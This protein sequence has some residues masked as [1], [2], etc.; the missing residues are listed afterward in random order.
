MSTILSIRKK[1]QI[2]KRVYQASRL[3][4]LMRQYPTLL[5]RPESQALNNSAT[6]RVEVVCCLMLLPPVCS[7]LAW[8]YLLM[9]KSQCTIRIVLSAP[10]ISTEFWIYHTLEYHISFSKFTIFFVT[11]IQSADQLLIELTRMRAVG[12]TPRPPVRRLHGACTEMP[13]GTREADATLHNK[14]SI[15]P[16]FKHVRDVAIKTRLHT[17]LSRRSLADP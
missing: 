4:L 16:S 10:C 5:H 8:Y 17:I 12:Q 15:F 13:D 6:I 2:A 7:M 3:R 1:I 9:S 11:D 14:Y